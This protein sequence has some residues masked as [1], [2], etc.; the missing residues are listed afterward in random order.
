MFHNLKCKEIDTRCFYALQ[1][2]SRRN[3]GINNHFYQLRYAFAPM[4]KLE[5]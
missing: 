3:Y 5:E 2:A 1:Y 4:A